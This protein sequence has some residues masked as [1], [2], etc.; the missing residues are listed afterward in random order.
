MTHCSTQVH[1]TH[2]CRYCT[3]SQITWLTCVL[4]FL[5]LSISWPLEYFRN[6]WIYCYVAQKNMSNFFHKHWWRLKGIIDVDRLIRLKKLLFIKYVNGQDILMNKR[7]HLIILSHK[8]GTL[9]WEADS[10]SA[11]W[12]NL[13]LIF[14]TPQIRIRS[15][16][17]KCRTEPVHR[18]VFDEDT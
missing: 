4:D 16:W 10:N 14:K 1:I 11:K 2:H 3:A 7:Q 9:C 17:L 12:R 15:L 5:D 8:T 18:L 13:F 6:C